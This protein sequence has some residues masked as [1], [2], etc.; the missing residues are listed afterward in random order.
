MGDTKNPCISVCEFE[1]RICVGCGRSKDE[2]KAWKKM[3]KPEK[4]EVLAE[5]QVRLKAL[6][7]KVKKKKKR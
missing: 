3:D 5:A 2:I 6:G 4:R 7:D 1:E